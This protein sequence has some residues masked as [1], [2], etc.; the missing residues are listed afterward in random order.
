[1]CGVN[2]TVVT[3]TNTPIPGCL[4]IT[5]IVDWGE[6]D[7][8]DSSQTFTITVTGPSYATP[9][10]ITFNY[11]GVPNVD[12]PLIN[13]IPGNYTI[14]ETDPG[15]EWIVEPPS[16]VQN[17]TVTPGQEECEQ[18]TFTNTRKGEAEVIKN[19]NGECNSNIT[20]NFTLDGPGVSVTDTTNASC[21]VDFEGAQLIPGENYTICELALPATWMTNWTMDS[22]SITPTYNSTTGDHC[23][24]FSAGVGE[25]IT[26]TIDNVAPGG[27]PRTPGYWK[28][29][30]NC[31]KGNQAATAARNG[32]PDEGFWLVGD[33]LALGDMYIGD[34][35]I[36]DCA[37]AVSILD[38][39]DVNSG[40]KRASDAAYKLAGNLL[41][42]ELNYGAGACTDPAVTDNMTQAHALL[43]SIS[44]DGT[45]KYL[46]PKG[47]N[48]NNGDRAEA[49]RLAGILDDYNNGV[50]CPY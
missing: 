40:K 34:L 27:E 22:T 15:V 5:K 39:R 19:T 38:R 3:V 9:L 30:N 44:F 4:N 8:E 37:T 11:T 17:V 32:G 47:K 14:N 36:D 33:V 43:S 23:Y 42:A 24:V 7:M 48:G 10:V 26:F 25:K 13:L 35:L 46:E 29:W 41:A 12:M 16:L 50:Y 2:A 21:H 20:W 31:T 45:G 6:G 1:V 28:N 18:V 49:L